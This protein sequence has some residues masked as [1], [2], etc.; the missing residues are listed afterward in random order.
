MSTDTSI[1]PEG[2]KGGNENHGTVDG[3]VPKTLGEQTT[4]QPPAGADVVDPATAPGARPRPDADKGE[5]SR[6]R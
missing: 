5:E 1:G 6:D 3:R 4:Q 2:Q